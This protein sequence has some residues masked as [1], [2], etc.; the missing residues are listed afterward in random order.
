MIISD[1]QVHSFV[2]SKICSVSLARGKEPPEKQKKPAP[3][4]NRDELCDKL[5]PRFHPRFIPPPE[6]E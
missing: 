6:A 2:F 3:V 5:N 1:I 4:K